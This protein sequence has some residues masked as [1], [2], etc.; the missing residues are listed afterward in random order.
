MAPHFTS[1]QMFWVGLALVAATLL[2]IVS[3]TGSQGSLPDSQ[4][5]IWLLALS[6]S[7]LQILQMLGIVLIGAGLVT[8][9]VEYYH[10][11]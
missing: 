6:G 1:A 10:G 7:V 11:D 9:V 5:G 3:I 2:G 8:R 4:T